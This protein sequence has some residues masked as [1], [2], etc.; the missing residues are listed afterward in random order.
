[1]SMGCEERRPAPRGRTL[2]RILG[3]CAFAPIIGIGGMF[4]VL[5]ACAA[6]RVPDQVIV[7]AMRFTL[8]SCIA[9]CYLAALV[10]SAMLLFSPRIRANPSW[11][12]GLLIFPYVLA[13]SF[14][15]QHVR[16]MDAEPRGPGARD[17]S[18]T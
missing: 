12:A 4:L 9:V 10:F 8:T 16:L 5:I 17:D 13:P 11:I 3:A 7:T 1:M 18:T 6:L 14:W 2:I 15:E